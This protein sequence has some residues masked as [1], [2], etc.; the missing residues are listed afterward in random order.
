MAKDRIRNIY[1]LTDGLVERARNVKDQSDTLLGALDN[2]IKDVRDADP[3]AMREVERARFRT[4][5]PRR[6]RRAP[7]PDEYYDEELEPDEEE[8]I[9]ARD[10][11]LED[12]PELERPAPPRRRRRRKRARR[13]AAVKREPESDVDD[14]TLEEARLEATRMAVSGA[15]RR[16]IRKRLNDD[17]DLED[18]DELIDEI[19]GSD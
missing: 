19:L 14:S 5:E 17:Y 10:V 1:E 9:A 2:A 12:E 4:R 18:S 13:R 3:E 8:S 7:E 11:E 6:R 15:S 16:Q